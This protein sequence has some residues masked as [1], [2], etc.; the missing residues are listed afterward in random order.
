MAEQRD[1]DP[2]VTVPVQPLSTAVK[3]PAPRHSL[4]RRLAARA[5]LGALAALLLV[6]LVLPL[7][8]SDDYLIRVAVETGLYII[9]ALGLNLVVGY[10]G[11]LDIGYVAFYAIGAYSYALLA[12]PQFNIHLPF[13][14]VLPIGS[15][16][17]AVLGILIGFPTLRLRGDYLAIVTLGFGEMIRF[18]LNNLNSVTNGPQGISGID[19]PTVGAWQLAT[20]RDFYYPVLGLCVLLVAVMVRVQ[21]SRVGRAWAAIREDEEAAI[22]LG[23]HTHA[24]KLLA[25][26]CGAAC[27]GIAGVLFAGEQGFVS[28]ESFTFWQ[29]IIILCMVVVGGMGSIVGVILGAVILTVL[30]EYLRAFSDWRLWIYGLVLLL[31]T[32]FRPAGLWPTAVRRREVAGVS[33]LRR[34]WPTR[35]S[36]P[37]PGVPMPGSQGSAE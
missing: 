30:P 31:V 4:L 14:A 5:E 32:V 9:L 16:L 19:V 27:A 6:G 10:C 20:P 11:L 33:P 28:P 12:S 36:E 15:A 24:Y 22:A 29:S 37:R 23:V 13:L 3:A 34:L 7:A 25:F 18:L 21:R 35:P 1:P 26:A 2:R 8:V 17:A